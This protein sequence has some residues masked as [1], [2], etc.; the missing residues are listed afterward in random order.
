MRLHWFLA[1]NL[2]FELFLICP[3]LLYLLHLVDFSETEM[4]ANFFRQSRLLS[5]Q[6]FIKLRL[7]KACICF[8]F[9]YLVNRV[10]FLLSWNWMK[11]RVQCSSFD[12]FKKFTKFN[13]TIIPFSLVAYEIVL[14]KLVIYHLISYATHA[15]GKLF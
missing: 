10:D 9:L 15:H 7:Q 11:N 3:R 12:D 4:V 5:I 6:I 2:N 13:K 8:D 14:A 1:I